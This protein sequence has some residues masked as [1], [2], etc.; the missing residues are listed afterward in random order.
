M[1]GANIV[2][3]QKDTVFNFSDIIKKFSS[4]D[5]AKKDTS[6]SSW[7]IA[8]N[9]I[10][11]RNTH[12]IYKDLEIG[13]RWE[14][15]HLALHVPSIYFSN[16]SSDIGLALN[17]ANG[18]SLGIKAQYNMQTSNYNLAINLKGFDVS[19]VLPYLQQSLN[20]SVLQ[21]ILST[22]LN[23]KGETNHVMNF[24]A[25][26]NVVLSNL[27]LRDRSRKNI[28]SAQSIMASVSKID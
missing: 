12:I 13:S 7:E 23:I 25:N 27:S 26:G 24:V 17:F 1:G 11:I 2:V 5:A 15:T 10:D 22:R 6:S 9:S 28:V 14:V 20:V 19:G 16:K 18:G 4:P 8:L 3:T 21:G